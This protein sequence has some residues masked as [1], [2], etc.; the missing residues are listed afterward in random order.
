MIKRFSSDQ[1]R[2][3]G[4]DEFRNSQHF[5]YTNAFFLYNLA[6]LKAGENKVKAALCYGNRSAVYMEMNYYSH[7][8]KNIELAEKHFPRDKLPRLQQR[9][10]KCLK[11]MNEDGMNN[12]KMVDPHRNAFRLSY[13]ANRT[14]PFFVNVLE[15]RENEKYGRHL[16]TTRDLKAGDVIFQADPFCIPTTKSQSWSCYNCERV[17]NF[18]LMAS[19]T[20]KHGENKSFSFRNLQFYIIDHTTNS[21]AGL[22]C[23]TKCID[24]HR[25][26]NDKTFHQL[27]DADH[28]EDILFAA[29]MFMK[30][31]ALF[32]GDIGEMRKFVESHGDKKHTLFDFDW[33][34]SEDPMYR[35]NM[36][37]VMLGTDVDKYDGFLNDVK[38]N[39]RFRTAGRDKIGEFLMSQIKT[40]GNKLKSLLKLNY[41]SHGA[42]MEKILE[43]FFIAFMFRNEFSIMQQPMRMFWRTVFFPARSLLNH[44]CNPNI[45]NHMSG[46]GKLQWIVNQPIPAG[47]QIFGG[48]Y[49]TFYV[50]GRPEPYCKFKKTCEPC[51][52]DWQHK[53]SK[54]SS[55]LAYSSV[56]KYF[57]DRGAFKPSLNMMMDCFKECCEFINENYE[58]FDK[59]PTV[60]KK[61]AM[62]LIE[63]RRCIDLIE[64]PVSQSFLNPNYRF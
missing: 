18:D 47:G 23:S 3:L 63:S 35:K 43:K 44:S 13:L 21:F 36:L 10:E 54:P 30:A 38:G 24:A 9:R 61:I 22:F 49:P 32:D 20:C 5:N 11:M 57:N 50:D 1:L 33:S 28:D 51:K 48:F 8:L 53:G 27:E 42:F 62:K 45:H 25:R 40:T 64:S 56:A 55:Q 19:V 17:N 59:K 41:R 6:L 52:L 39:L 60:R 16:I 2:E 34:N 31:Q 15:L 26:E 58:D 14:V 37:L 29:N 7:C 12:D 4:N 46:D